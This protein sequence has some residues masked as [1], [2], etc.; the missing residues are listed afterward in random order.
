MLFAFSIGSKG[1]KEELYSLHLPL[2]FSPGRK[3][4]IA[5]NKYEVEFNGLSFLIE[6]HHYLYTLKVF[7]FNSYVEAEAFKNHILPSIYWIA[8]KHK[9]GIEIPH[10]IDEIRIYEE[11]QVVSEKSDLYP[12]IQ[13][14]GWDTLDGNY[15]VDKLVIIPENKRL[16]RWENGKATITLG[17]GVDNFLEDL[18]Y[19]LSLPNIEHVSTDKKLCL[20][21]QIYSSFSFEIT[22]TSKLIKLVTVLESLLPEENISD[23]ANR[24][25]KAAKNLIKLE[26]NS[27]QRKGEPYDEI[28]KLINRVGNISKQSIGQCLIIYLNK[29]SIS[30]PSLLVDEELIKKLKKAYDIRSRMLHDGEFDEEALGR[31]VITLSVFIPK[32]LTA[33]CK[34]AAGVKES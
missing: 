6:K 1:I 32:L 12:T 2:I 11:S 15:D 7:P 24:I 18:N 28:E 13:E 34:E 9:F 21:I 25:L 30:I 14:L 23:D 16:T 29:I 19:S 27:A 3:I 22:D 8:L 31:A 5:E 10:E 17:L 26:L 4:S 33:L 20:A